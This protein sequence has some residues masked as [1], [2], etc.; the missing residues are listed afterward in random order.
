MRPSTRHLKQVLENNPSY[1]SESARNRQRVEFYLLLLT[2]FI[3]S[4]RALFF[5]AHAWRTLTYP[6]E[7]STM[8]GYYV[9][10]G[11]RL[12]SGKPIYFDYQSLLTPFEYPPLYPLLIGVLTKIFGIA[13]WPERLFSLV[14]A[15]GIAAIIARVVFAQSANRW[16]AACAGLLFFAPA[17]LSVWHI[18]RGIDILTAFLSLGAVVIAARRSA[19][20][21]A[22]AAS[23]ILFVFAFFSKQTAVFP[24][25]A[26]VVFFIVKRQWKSGL[27]LA[28]GFTSLSVLLVGSLEYE[29]GGWFFKNAFLT[30]SN[31]PFYARLL[32]DLFL[33]FALALPIVLPLAFYQALKDFHSSRSVWSF[34]FFFTLASTALASKAG[35]ALSY[36]IPVFSGVCILAGA[37]MGGGSFR[38]PRASA[39]RMILLLLALQ[40]V[41]FFMEK[42][43]APTEA[44][45]REAA[46]LDEIIQER[47]GPILTERID[48]FAVRNGR[49]LNVEAV[50]LPVLVMRRE[51]DPDIIIGPVREKRFSLIVYSGIYF[52]GIP[53]I[54]KAIFENYQAIDEVE[55][56]LFFGKLKFLVMAPVGASSR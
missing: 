18:V 1:Q 56:G 39:R 45:Y 12:I 49:D 46:A 8:D 48:S 5:F 7:W 37:W 34:Y 40:S 10:H 36:F 4:I 14:C 29:S 43:P 20:F 41:W 22:I 19:G 42:Y 44:D 17:S 54:K 30:T 9:F 26:V 27:F 33:K 21:G 11:L 24:L 53:A 47:P 6:F 55:I 28:A 3:L 31:N 2:T 50:Q 23:T 38:E 25:A 15:L 16:A 51:V 35:A 13:V 52:G 32:A